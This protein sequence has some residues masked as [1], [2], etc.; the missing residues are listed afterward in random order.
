MIAIILSFIVAFSLP[1]MTLGPAYPFSHPPWSILIL[2]FWC[3]HAPSKVGVLAGFFV[4]L[5]LDVVKVETLG[6]NAL[7]A[8]LI[9]YL[10][11]RFQF[12]LRPLPPPLLLP[13][14]AP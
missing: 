1:V 2:I 5:L 7:G 12:Q 13:W 8:A 4:G 6:L 10:A 14:P 9:A 11:C 3:W